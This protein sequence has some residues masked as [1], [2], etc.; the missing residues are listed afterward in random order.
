MQ[1]LKKK[2]FKRLFK[3]KRQHNC[4][5]VNNSIKTKLELVKNYNS[6]DS[7]YEN[8]QE[9]KS[10][11]TIDQ[12]LY[13]TE[14]DNTYQF[15]AGFDVIDYSYLPRSISL[16]RGGTV[17]KG[18]LGT[19]TF[20]DFYDKIIATNNSNDWIDGISNGGVIADLE[21]NL[22]K[23]TLDINNLPGI[24]SISS[25][26][27]KFENIS[28]SN[29]SDNLIGNSSNNKILGN[30]G[31]DY[32]F[33]KRGKDNIF[34]GD[35]NDVLKGGRGNDKLFGDAGDDLIEGG[36]GRDILNGG[37][38]AD[39]FI[40]KKAKDSR[41]NNKKDMNKADWIKDFNTDED[42]I[43]FSEAK[44][45]QTLMNLGELDYLSAKSINKAL[46]ENSNKDFNTIC[47]NVISSNKTFLAIN[48]SGLGFQ[49]KNDLLLDITGYTGELENINILS[50]GEFTNSNLV[51]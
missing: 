9:N 17:N 34:G 48:G 24:G 14:G 19:D 37:M 3:K 40:Y 22:S 21:I 45:K 31:N 5:L 27:E 4:R 51:V 20:I 33:G 49:G 46:E 11:S 1:R 6:L 2:E 42:K 18:V 13:G 30:Q 35:G 7:S 29:N 32:I 39:T 44:E 10:S 26:I 15:G 25:L 36:L 16:V 43:Y 38:G 12:Y 47:F 41:L 50:T 8:N 23:G 28:A